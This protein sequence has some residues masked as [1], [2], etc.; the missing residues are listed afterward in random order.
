MP[1]NKLYGGE[2]ENIGTNKKVATD[3]K[4]LKKNYYEVASAK[5]K[6]QIF[7]FA[8]GYKNFIN[9][10]K[11]EREANDFI[12]SEAKQKGYS[13]YKFGDKLKAGDKKY[14]TNRDKG[15]VLFKIGSN[16][17]EK[18]GI[19]M[20]ASHIDCPRLD[21]KQIPLF[22]SDGFCFLKTHYYGGIKKYQ[23][24]AM[25]LALHGVVVLKNG[26]KLK[27]SIGEKEDD[28]VFY[29]NDLLPHLSQKQLALN[30]RE[31][32]S[33]EQL[34]IVVGGLP[35]NNKDERDKIKANIL[36]ILNKDYGMVEEDF[37]SSELSVVP[38][39]KAKDVGLD[40]ALIGGYGQDDRVCAY[41]AYKGLLNTDSLNTA[42]CI[43]VDKEEIGSEGNTGIKSMFFEDVLNDICLSLGKNVR[44]V[45]Q[46]SMCISAD[47]TSAFDPNFADVF[48]KNNSAMLS[49]GVSM[50]KY[51]GSAGKSGSSD[52]SAETVGKIRDI[53]ARHNVIW[54]TSE[55]GKVDLGG[56]GTVAKF[57]A[58]LNI[59][60][61]DI[62]VPVISMH[63]PYELVSKADL[64]SAYTA[65]TAF[66]E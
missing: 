53:F 37:I 34:N 21:L 12:I 20:V 66:Y 32:I 57:V 23:W 61:V 7:D 14:I 27:I 16:D 11:T 62:G 17:I 44:K 58:Q 36:K 43:L 30:A 52:A 48:E 64:Y 51:T 28:P 19:R 31:V 6:K 41:A 18:D 46:K 42:M 59:D 4:Y 29:I 35:L 24:T 54:Q 40:R 3:Y 1:N 5:E 25:P 15:V 13:E 22:E 55:L 33:G 47:V 2:M 65:Y 38:A 39:F 8:E 49:C 26:K 63:A 10:C 45:R 56:G 60:T 50:E 9:N